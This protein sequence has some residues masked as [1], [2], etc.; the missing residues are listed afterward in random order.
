M[1]QQ[2]KSCFSFTDIKKLYDNLNR[3]NLI[4]SL[5]WREFKQKQWNFLDSSRRTLK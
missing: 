1:C 5:I 4:S 3:A 2:Q